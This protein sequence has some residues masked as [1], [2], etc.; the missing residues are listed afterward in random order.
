MSNEKLDIR[1]YLIP[2][3]Q[4][5]EELRRQG[6]R[7]L[8]AWQIDLVTTEGYLRRYHEA[9]SLTTTYAAAWEVVESEFR[10]VYKTKR[11]DSYESFRNSSTVQKLLR[12]G[13]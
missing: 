10:A 1:G 3:E 13:K 4:L 8:A 6:Y 11:F 2:A 9:I 7:L 12:N 5:E